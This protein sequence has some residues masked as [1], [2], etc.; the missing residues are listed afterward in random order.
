MKDSITR[1]TVGSE[2]MRV[3]EEHAHNYWKGDGKG[4]ICRGLIQ[5]DTSP[6][7]GNI[8]NNGMHPGGLKTTREDIMV[9]GSSLQSTHFSAA[10]EHSNQHSLEFLNDQDLMQQQS[11]YAQTHTHTPIHVHIYTHTHKYNMQHATCNMQFTHIHT[12]THT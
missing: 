5:I 2:C 9:H 6:C 12:H 8:R 4:T 3:R 7:N 11:T 1:M 10:T